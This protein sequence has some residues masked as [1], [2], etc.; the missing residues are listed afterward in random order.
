MKYVHNKE[1]LVMPSTEDKPCPFRDISNNCQSIKS[2]VQ[3]LKL[4]FQ[5]HHGVCLK[6]LKVFVDK[7]SVKLHANK[8]H[9]VTKGLIK[10]DTGEQKCKLCEATFVTLT[11]ATSHMREYHWVCNVCLLPFQRRIYLID[12]TIKHYTSKNAEEC[13]FL[14]CQSCQSPVHP[15]KYRSHHFE[16][17]F[18]CIDCCLNFAN[19]SDT[20]R[21]AE[22]V[23]KMN[24]KCKK[25]LFKSTDSQQLAMHQ[26]KKHTKG[27][28]TK[29]H[30]H[31][32]HLCPFRGPRAELRNH[33]FT[34]HFFCQICKLPYKT[35]GLVNDHVMSN[36]MKDAVCEVCFFIDFNLGIMK[37]HK[38]EQHQISVPKRLPA[39]CQRK[40]YEEFKCKKCR[41]KK[42]LGRESLMIHHAEKH[43]SCLICELSFDS[44]EQ[45]VLHFQDIHKKKWKCD[46]CNYF[47]T[48]N[49]T[50][51]LH[52]SK[53]HSWHD[54]VK[55]QSINVVKDIIDNVLIK[56]VIPNPMEESPVKQKKA[57]KKALKWIKWSHNPDDL[58]HMINKDHDYVMRGNH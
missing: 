40:T 20:W 19:E 21:H 54:K 55:P 31:V 24:V 27:P 34:E 23:H 35:W 56:K 47:S 39:G 44:L 53:C 16:A 12:H 50:T 7:K 22:E 30:L 6:C 45:V 15:K 11:E 25:C 58:A 41:F 36:H 28:S 3:G 4:H 32:C 10:V 14:E 5:T 43:Q 48:N 18:H 2:S 37:K 29:L 38:E 9:Q 57:V 51:S 13:P 49:R 8:Y 46:F 1:V 42:G 26:L 33:L 17:H 52:V